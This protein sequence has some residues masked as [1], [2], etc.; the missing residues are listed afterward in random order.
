M[1]RKVLAV[2]AVVA[3]LCIATTFFGCNSDSNRN[4][5]PPKASQDI[6]PP[7]LMSFGSV[8]TWDTDPNA[9]EYELYRNGQYEST[10]TGSHYDAGQVTEDCEYTVV[11]KNGDKSSTKSNVARVC[12]NSSYAEGEVLDLS[13][14]SSYNG[15][16]PNSVRK[17]VI[18]KQS[19]VTM[20]FCC[21]IAE[22][23]NDLTIELSNVSLVGYISTVNCEYSRLKH[24]Y[25]VIIDVKAN[26]SVKSSDGADG[27]DFSDSVYDNREVDA[28]SGSDANNAIIV[29]SLVVEGEGAL[30]IS[31]GNGGNGGVGSSTTK[32]EA[33][34]GPGAGADGGDGGAGLKTSYCVVN[35]NGENSYVSVSDGKGGKKGKPGNNGSII[36]GPAAS[37]MWKDM[38]D[39]GKAGKDGKS[40]FGSIKILGGKFLR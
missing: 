2:A 24:N 25:N 28:G 13:D 27:F 15:T 20:S 14:S 35:M 9:T 21:L 5:I 16:L 8:L 34:N 22:R 10:V 18:R 26:C 6:L 37:A 17:I 32:W 1:N 39:I 3:P 11:A 30:V 19:S 4:R 40:E 33:S 23:T 36:T 38:Y 29:P 12:K 7:Y 31:G